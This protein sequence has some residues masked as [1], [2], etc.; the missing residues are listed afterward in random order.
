MEEGGDPESTLCRPPD[1]AMDHLQVST[2]AVRGLTL[3]KQKLLDIQR[4]LSARLRQRYREEIAHP[5]FL[6]LH[7][8]DAATSDRRKHR[9]IGR[10]L[11][12]R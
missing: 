8:S 5:E 7:L 12:S 6:R 11:E 4:V 2:P 9:M 10:A 3:A 1:S